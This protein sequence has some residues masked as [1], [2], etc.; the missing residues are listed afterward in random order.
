MT[1]D[2][3]LAGSAGVAL[4][5]DRQPALAKAQDVDEGGGG[6]P[7]QPG[8]DMPVMQGNQNDDGAD[9]DTDGHGGAG[10]HAYRDQLIPADQLPQYADFISLANLAGSS[11]V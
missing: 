11:H 2:A 7:Q 4:R 8:E 5:R 10:I 3:P 1:L 9:D 6:E